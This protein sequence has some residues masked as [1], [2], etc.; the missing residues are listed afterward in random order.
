[1]LNQGDHDISSKLNPS[2]L[3]EF[4]LAKIAKLAKVGKSEKAAPG[5]DPSGGILRN[6]NLFELQAAWTNA[7]TLVGW[8]VCHVLWRRKYSECA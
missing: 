6:R 4:Q 7:P 5:I 8:D 1:M 3:E 2:I